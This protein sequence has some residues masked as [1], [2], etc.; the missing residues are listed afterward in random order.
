MRALARGIVALEWP[1]D[2]AAGERVDLVVLGLGAGGL[3]EL[4]ASTLEDAAEASR[5]APA[6]HAGQRVASS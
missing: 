6:S 1:G 2:R 4:G 3:V 5:R